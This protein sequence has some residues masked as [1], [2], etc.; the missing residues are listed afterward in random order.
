MIDFSENLQETLKQCSS[1]LKNKGI[2][3]SKKELEWFCQKSFNYSL[4]DIHMNSIFLSIEEIKLLKSFIDRRSNHEPFQYIIN[5]APF[6][7]YDFFVNSRV[8][9]PRPETEIIFKILKNRFFKTALDVGTGSGNI[10]IALKL[11]KI[12][13]SVTAID[14][15]DEALKVAKFNAQSFNAKDVDFYKIN[16]FEHKFIKGYDLV[17]SNPPYISKKDYSFLPENIKNY[18]PKTALTD[19]GDGYSFY[20]Y[21]AHNINILLKPKGTM[22][23]E[24]GLE[25]TKNKIEKIFENYA[26]IIWHK[27]YNYDYRILEVNV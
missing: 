17:V 23:I 1:I 13:Q 21:F 20:K 8:L 22:I 26:N 16:I 19:N 2:T 4:I 9:I 7:E 18:E 3:N 5:S 12:A 11:K 14:C 15:D 25:N 6:L 10:A 27:D 24:I